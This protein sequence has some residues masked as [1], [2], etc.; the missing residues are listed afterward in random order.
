MVY[1]PLRRPLLVH[2]GVLSDSGIE[3]DELWAFSLD[4]GPAWTRIGTLD[5]LR[6][7]SYPMDVYDPTEDR[8]LACGGSG[9]P[10]VS[11]LSLTNPVRW[12]A[13]L[14]PF[15]LLEPGARSRAAMVLDTRRRRYVVLGGDYSPADSAV[16]WFDPW[17]APLWRSVR[18]DPAPILPWDAEYS[19]E[20]VYDS[21]GD[22]FVLFDGYQVWTSPVDSTLQWTARYPTG[23]TLPPAPPDA[24][25]AF[26]PRADRLYVA[27]DSTVWAR[28][29]EDSGPWTELS[30][31]NPGPRVTSAIAWD[32]VEDQ[33]LAPFAAIP[34]SDHVR[35][36]AVAPGPL[37]VT[38]R[39]ANR[40]PD[41]I[42]LEWRSVTAWGRAAALE[43]REEDTDWL[44]IESLDFDVQ[45]PAS[46]VD[47]GAR[48]GHDYDYRVAVATDSTLWHS[49]AVFVPDPASLRLALHGARPNPAV[50]SLAIRFSLPASGPARLEIFDVRGRRCWSAEVGG[51]GPGTHVLRPAPAVGWRPGVYFARLRRAGE[52]RTARLV[53]V[54]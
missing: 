2:G 45:G 29:V 19:R 41:G 15:P 51:M 34:G 12:D 49:D 21:L 18:S 28:P 47:P 54:R 35:V 20:A 3:P 6:G 23:V 42:E 25:A 32:P 50:G 8:L 40:T 37:S 38:L 11:A 14:P 30:F 24:H 44:G 16:W 46:I 9:C 1:D 5:R 22:R 53:L 7:R 26:D 10:Q 43:R 52:E 13:V 4:G 27:S 39:A 33:L 31:S 36:W 17:Q 48:P